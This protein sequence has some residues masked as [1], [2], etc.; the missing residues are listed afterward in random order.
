MRV[1]GVLRGRRRQRRAFQVMVLACLLALVPSGWE[2][3][4]QSSRIRTVADV[5]A[6]P[7]AVVFGAQVVGEEPSPYLAARLDAALDLYR[8][9]KVQAILVTGDNSH[10]DYNEPGA[11][12]QYLVDHGV[13]AV[14]VVRDYAGFNT[15]DSCTRA[16]R[17]FGVDHAV[18]VSTDYHVRRAL[19]LCRAAGID[20]YAVGAP[21]PHDLTWYAGSVRE[22]PGAG[23]ALFSAVFTPDPALLGP[24]DPGVTR[25]L[26]DSSG[27]R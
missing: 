15:W 21:E 5:P 19:A 3:L 27:R 22:L 24:S 20:S 10:P 26:A 18:L 6:E 8:A 23:K 12:Y 7:V 1:S 2:F 17:I 9:H 4:T 16:R 13:P 14:K 11:M 25:A